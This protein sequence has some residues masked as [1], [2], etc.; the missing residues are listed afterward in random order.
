MGVVEKH[1]MLSGFKVREAMRRQVLSLPDSKSVG[2][3]ISLL[4][5]YKISALL[6]TDGDGRPSGVV[7]KTDIMN[8]YYADFPLDQELRSIAAASPITC[9]EQDPLE[10]ALEVMR[11]NRIYRLYVYDQAHTRIVG[12][13]AY[14]DIVGLLYRL[15]RSCKRNYLIQKGVR[16]EAEVIRRFTVKEVMTPNVQSNRAN[17]TLYTLMEALSQYR[18][19]AVLIKD[20][21][22]NPV[23]VVSKT[24]LI[25]AYK[26]GISPERPA[27]EIMSSKVHGCE[28]SAY[29][30]E[31]IQQMIFSDIHRLFVY[32]DRPENIVGVLSFTDAA[33]VRSGSCRACLTTR[34]KIED[35]GI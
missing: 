29:L 20:H 11:Q 31:A 27:H 19:G 33:R 28:A 18:F 4:I 15:C 30:A 2:K 24:D 1:S 17:D 7:S 23:G 26:H 16:E 32:Q 34:I 10:A 12:L 25:L 35:Q 14:P 5:K 8:A 21:S 9:T 6:L 22:D 13:L 3:A